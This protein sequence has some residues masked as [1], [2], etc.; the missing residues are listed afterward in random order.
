MPFGA[1][2]FSLLEDALAESFQYHAALDNFVRRSGIPDTR[3][4]AARAQAEDRA[5]GSVRSFSRAPKRFVAQKLLSDLGSGSEQEDRLVAGLVTAVCKGK[6]PDAS[7]KGKTAIETL[8]AQ[9]FLEH[10]EAVTRR[11]ELRAEERSKERTRER[12]AADNAAAREGFKDA[13]LQLS[14]QSDA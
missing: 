4:A 5:K 11:D 2:I 6:F 14:Q 8:T 10:Q 13:F 3:L 1:H 7:P 12:A 9:R